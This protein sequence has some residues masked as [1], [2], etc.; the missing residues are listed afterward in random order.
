MAFHT[1]IIA[2]FK[3]GNKWLIIRMDISFQMSEKS[4]HSSLRLIT[5]SYPLNLGGEMMFGF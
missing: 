5:F 4:S 2:P 1:V 3:K